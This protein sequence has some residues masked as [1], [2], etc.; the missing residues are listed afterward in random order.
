MSKNIRQERAAPD[1][2]ASIRVP[3]E[4]L[5][6]LVNLVGEMVTVQARL[7]QVA[8]HPGGFHHSSPSPK[9]WSA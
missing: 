8:N 2:A 7:T 4:R 9:R 6:Q 3:A 1:A 5:D